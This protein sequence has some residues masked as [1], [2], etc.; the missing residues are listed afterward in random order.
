MVSNV[1]LITASEGPSMRPK[2]EADSETGRIQIVAPASWLAR[3]E[4]WRRSQPKIPSRSEA[5][6]VLVDQALG[7]T[8]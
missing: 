3:V 5:I 2:L 7:V 8:G 1:H 6:R 4:E